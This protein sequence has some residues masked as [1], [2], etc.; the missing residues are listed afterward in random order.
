MDRQNCAPTTALGVGCQLTMTA[1]WCANACEGQRSNTLD[2]NCYCIPVPAAGK[3]AKRTSGSKTRK[4][5]SEKRTCYGDENGGR[6]VNPTMIDAHAFLGV[7]PYFVIAL[8]FCAQ[9]FFIRSESR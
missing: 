6:G 5:G 2:V 4:S 8:R 7:Q 1:S 3:S 9:R